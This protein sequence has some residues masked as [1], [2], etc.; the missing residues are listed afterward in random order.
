MN[1]K[2]RKFVNGKVAQT[3][4]KVGNL[5]YLVFSDSDAKITIESMNSYKTYKLIYPFLY[6]FYSLA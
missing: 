5:L 6:L 4:N 2:E 1:K 3:D